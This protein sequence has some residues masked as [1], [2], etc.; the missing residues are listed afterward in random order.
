MGQTVSFKPLIIETAL[1]AVDLSCHPLFNGTDGSAVNM[2]Q[3]EEAKL[4]CLDMLTYHRELLVSRVRSI[5]CIVDNLSACGFLCEEEVEI[6]QQTVTK[7]DQVGK[8][9]II[10]N[11]L[12]ESLNEIFFL[13]EVLVKNL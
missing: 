9:K 1:R 12:I 8:K 2:G 5:Q 7:V 11:G 4:S 13:K 6:V 10:S 3:V